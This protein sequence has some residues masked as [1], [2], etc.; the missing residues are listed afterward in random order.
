MFTLVSLFCEL[1]VFVNHLSKLTVD[2]DL[3]KL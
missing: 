3:A 2:T 1:H